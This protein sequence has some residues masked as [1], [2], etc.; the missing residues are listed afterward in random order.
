MA[1]TNRHDVIDPAAPPCYHL[2]NKELYVFNDMVDETH[3]EHDATSFWCLRTMKGF[4][5][6][7]HMV[8]RLECR[9]R[10][11]SCYEPS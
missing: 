10:G 9:D 8:G 7:D 2:R 6:D 5:P 11:R 3:G 4:G 1:E